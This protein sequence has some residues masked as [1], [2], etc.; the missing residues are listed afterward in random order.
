[1]S[2]PDH[3][4]DRQGGE[5]PL[6]MDDHRQRRS[7]G[8]APIT[9]IVSILL[10]VGVGGGVVYMYRS[11]VKGVDPASRSLG[12]PLG[13]V[14]APPPV[15]APTN[16]AAAGLSISRDDAGAGSSVPTLAPPPEEPLPSPPAVA[17]A[18]PT[19]ESQAQPSQGAASAVSVPSKVVPI[20]PPPPRDA[21]AP[22][23]RNTSH[24]D[25]RPQSIDQLLDG[26]ASA[27]KAKAK[28]DRIKSD[29]TKADR[30]RADRIKADEASAAGSAP[31]AETASGSVAI[32][33]GAF[34]SERLADQEWSRAAALAPGAM[35]G[36]GKRVVPV[37]KDGGTLYRTSITGFSSRD[38]A[39]ALCDRFKAAGGRC[40]VH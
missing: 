14:R 11:G 33:I 17:G 34:S 21:A 9:L 8:P 12:K 4:F 10:L 29:K 3:R 31:S 6:R 22:A 25:T 32:Q 39:L 16:D 26:Q 28:A 38:Q 23:A 24:P 19:L 18:P 5:A 27:D 7:R 13:D 1:M 15:G 40:F 35:A 37:A 30:N 20:P 2:D 36:K